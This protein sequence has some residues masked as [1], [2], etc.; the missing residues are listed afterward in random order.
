MNQ[1]S[2]SSELKL[3]LI[4]QNNEKEDLLFNDFAYKSRFAKRNTKEGADYRNPFSR[5]ADR[6][7]HSLSY[8]RY[9][10]KTQVFGF[11]VSSDIYQQRLLHVQIVSK[12]AREIA[13]ILN[14]NQDLVEAIA[15]GHDIGH[16]PFG[17]DGERILTKLCEKQGIGQ[18][19]HNYGSVWFLQ[20]IEM[21]NLTLPV[22]DGILGHNGEHH[23]PKVHL[24]EKSLT[25]ENFSVQMEDVLFSRM[26]DPKPSTLEGIVVRF[27][28]TISYISRDILDAEHL[29]IVS[30]SDIPDNIQNVLGNTNRGI[31]N[32]LISDLI[33]NSLGKP[34]ISYSPSI[35]KGLRELY[36]FNVSNIY[37]HP[38]KYK[39][40][41]KIEQSFDVLWEKY[42]LDLTSGNKNS[43]IFTDHLELNLKMI[44]TRYPEIYSVDNY[45]YTKNPPEI[46]VRD[47]IAGMT[48][49][50]FWNLVKKINPSLII[51]PKEYF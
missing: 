5:D 24:N 51:H 13:H 9:F 32:T 46:I 48:E 37:N 45:P 23:H 26:V 4:K 39:H 2:I 43:E 49:R 10:D 36:Q 33:K 3:K 16:V 44:K 38:E 34:Y 18:Y 17:H 11:W 42:Y 1:N 7:L 20:E 40:M 12:M 8:A 25:W 31:I 50:Y 21:Q 27:V 47:F 14:L 29:G 15:L 30:F 19:H 6:I 28:D 22:L 35:F 41:K